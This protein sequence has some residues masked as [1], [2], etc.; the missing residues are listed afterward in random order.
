[1]NTDAIISECQKHRYM[2]LRQWNE[3][4]PLVMFIGLNPSKADK[5]KNDR[6]ISR[7]MRFAYDWGYGG[8]YFANLFSYRTP[9]VKKVPEKYKDVY[10]PLLKV[11]PEAYND[12]TNFWLLEMIK[13]S[14][15]VI[16]AWGSWNFIGARRTEV[17]SFIDNRYCLGINNDGEPKHPLY[18]LSTTK[19]IEYL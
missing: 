11:L 4:K 14:E 9:Y 12:Q 8:I 13:N 5:T 6:T 16:C 18:L 19:P 2:L 1:M 7:C 10:E 17:L 15:K 3:K